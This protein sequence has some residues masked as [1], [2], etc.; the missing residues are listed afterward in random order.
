MQSDPV[1]NHYTDDGPYSH[2]PT[3]YPQSYPQKVLP[4]SGRCGILIA[5]RLKPLGDS[6]SKVET[7]KVSADREEDS[8]TGLRL[9]TAM[10]KRY[11]ARFIPE[12]RLT[13]VCGR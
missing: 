9:K 2:C 3:C 1:D 11:Y 10:W 8:V 13:G 5:K 12:L 6:T 4:E 7:N